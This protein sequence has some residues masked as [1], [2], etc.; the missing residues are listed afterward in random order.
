VAADRTLGLERQ[1]DALAL[2]SELRERGLILWTLEPPVGDMHP[3]RALRQLLEAIEDP[4][5]RATALAQLEEL[6]A[7]RAAVAAAAGDSAALGRA[8]DQANDVFTRLT[9]RSAT[10][11]GGRTYAA[12]SILFEDCRRDIDLAIG[13]A[14]RHFAAP[15]ALMLES[16][17]WFS[18]SVATHL[19]ERFAAIFD[20]LRAETG[21]DEVPFQT[22]WARAEPLTI[23]GNL[24]EL[25]KSSTVADEVVAELQARW[26]EL[27]KLS[28]DEHRQQY[29]AEELAPRVRAAFAAPHSGYAPVRHH[30][31]DIMIAAADGWESIQRGD[32]LFVLGEIHAGV[33]SYCSPMFLDHCPDAAEVLRDRATD[34]PGVEIFPVMNKD[35]YLRMN[36]RTYGREFAYETGTARS[37]L[38]RERVFAA[39]DFYLARVGGELLAFHRPDGRAFD[40][41]TFL[42]YYLGRALAH[43]CNWIAPRPHT[44]RV[45]IDKLVLARET[46]RFSSDELAFARIESRFDRFVAARGWATGHGMPR[47]VFVKVPE[48]KKPFF[49]DF[50]STTYVDHLAHIARGASRMV[51][52]EMLPAIG[53]SWLTDREGRRYVCEMRTVAVDPNIGP[54]IVRGGD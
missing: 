30:S 48:E 41:A 52:S 3:E 47:Y 34:L 4:P 19:L 44:P 35:Q 11:R 54:Q 29:S 51:V 26:A 25:G 36:V 2:L 50:E 8:L 42:D 16:V 22:F 20:Q 40:L 43:A 37:W 31:P 32:C 7:Q 39:T 9:A 1:E 5:L 45:T 15:L 14:V 18:H 24:V 21:S 23:A 27:L 33:I 10:R 53:E 46:W 49:V 13:S 6:E 38:P 12:R 28:P 17:R